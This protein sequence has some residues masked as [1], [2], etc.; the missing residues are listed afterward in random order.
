MIKIPF[1]FIE[2]DIINNGSGSINRLK[3]K[4]HTEI[5]FS[6]AA[7][8]ANGAYAEAITYNRSV[9]LKQS[10]KKLRKEKLKKAARSAKLEEEERTLQTLIEEAVLRKNRKKLIGFAT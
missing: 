10:K 5:L 7:S 9:M 8:G 3:I 6:Y 2:V 1:F 4:R